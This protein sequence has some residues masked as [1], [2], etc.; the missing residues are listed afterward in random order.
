MIGKQIPRKAS[1]VATRT[2]RSDFRRLVAYVCRKAVAV[3]MRNVLGDV[4]DAADEMWV[5]ATGNDRCK[6]KTL[7][8]VLSWPATERPTPAQAIEAME[9]M[10]TEL[11]LD[12]HQAAI[13]V[14]HDTAQVHVHAAVNAI[15]PE[16]LTK[17][18]SANSYLRIELACRKIELAQ[19]WSQDRGRFDI[20]VGE[21]ANGPTVKLVPKPQSHWDDKTKR[22]AVGRGSFQRDVETE[23]KTGMP[24]LCDA[25]SE[26]WKARMRLVLDGAADWAVVHTGLR[27]IGLAYVRK[28][29]GAQ[30]RIIGSDTAMSASQLGGR[31]ARKKMEARL[32]PF[33]D[34]TE[35]ND[36]TAAPL[37][38]DR[39]CRLR[40][41]MAEDAV[42]LTKSQTFKATLLARSYIGMILDDAMVRAIKRVDLNDIP[43]RITLMDGSV[44]VD[45]G[46]ELSA[47]AGGDVAVQA[48]LMVA[49]AKA[50]GWSD[51]DVEGSPDFLRAIARAAAEA[52]LRLTGV[53]DEIAADVAAEIAGRSAAPDGA[54]ITD[55]TAYPAATGPGPAHAAADAAR[56]AVAVMR[57]EDQAHR[58]ALAASQAADRDE[59]AETMG[60][61][62]SPLANAVKLG[63]DMHHRDQRRQRRESRERR[64]TLE[65]VP[66]SAQ[67][68]RRRAAWRVLT[69]S[70]AAASRE[71]DASALP[72]LD[73]TACR[74]LWA[75]ADVI[76]PQTAGMDRRKI[77]ATGYS[78]Q[79]RDLRVL[80]DGTI[81]FAHRDQAHNILGF[82]IARQA[83]DGTIQSAFAQSG[84]RTGVMFGDPATATRLVISTWA[85]DAKVLQA[86]EDRSDT[87]YLSLGGRVDADTTAR[88]QDFAADRAVVIAMG[89]ENLARDLTA[90]FPDATRLSWPDDITSSGED[91]ADVGAH[92]GRQDA[93]YLL[94][95]SDRN[96]TDVLTAEEARQD[97]SARDDDTSDP[98]VP[99]SNAPEPGTSEP[100]VV[101]AQEHTTLD[102]DEPDATRIGE[103]VVPDALDDGGHD[104]GM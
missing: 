91:I 67:D 68:R 50:K 51:C 19:G 104:L 31:F 43:P 47:S 45:E 85:A 6:T 22:R 80:P 10:L 82:E 99:A 15:H 38:A 3:E 63:L 37:P 12:D 29:S 58:A 103:S 21:D 97:A 61:D 30:I 95:H 98:E 42:A 101:D 35:A 24:P 72:Q 94:G 73:H 92:E 76:A 79:A 78:D 87:I 54:F 62:A 88:V 36:A 7:H 70:D 56:E 39:P 52:G 83:V 20:K 75:A 96:E 90:R 46:S 25:L 64:P 74:Q 66:L 5:I 18:R 49:M 34:R 17:W 71:M 81:L 28:G 60:N 65:T 8:F 41:R 55:V 102:T 11:G 44:I 4:A 69:G 40:G 26:P 13:G 57:Q 100:A 53:P 86:H 77:D 9:T 23:R 48:R 32:G 89:D 59:L 2:T 14:H 1:G 93:P 27:E 16:R 84:R 33:A